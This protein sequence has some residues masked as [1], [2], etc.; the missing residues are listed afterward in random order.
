[1]TALRLWSRDNTWFSSDDGTRGAIT[2][3]QHADLAVLSSD[4][5]AVPEETIGALVSDLTVVGGRIVHGA[6]D[7][8]SYGPP[9]PPAMPDWSPVRTFGGYG[10]AA[11]RAPAA[12]AAPPLASACAVH[13]GDRRA[14]DF[15]SGGEGAPFWSL[16]G[17]SCWAF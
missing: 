14:W 9:L 5:F 10:G 12:S 8:G 1:V 3:G 15:A 17:C 13:R 6:G 4:Y 11:A 7:F 16:L 2:V